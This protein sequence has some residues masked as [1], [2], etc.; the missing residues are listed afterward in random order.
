M[1]L[2]PRQRNPVDT[3]A[4]TLRTATADA[5]PKTLCDALWTPTLVGAS[6]TCR[7]PARMEAVD[8]KRPFSGGQQG[9]EGYMRLKLWESISVL[10][11]VVF[12]VLKGGESAWIRANLQMSI[13]TF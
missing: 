1:R 2:C 9:K 12:W 6:L 8:F 3:Q 7:G 11:R 10:V 4:S 13:R 5:R